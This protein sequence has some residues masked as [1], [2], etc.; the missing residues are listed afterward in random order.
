MPEEAPAAAP[1]EHVDVSSGPAVG[2]RQNLKDFWNSILRADDE[3]KARRNLH[4]CAKTGL[5]AEARRHT[6]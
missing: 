1:E 4:V 2:A 5:V 6:R 3:A